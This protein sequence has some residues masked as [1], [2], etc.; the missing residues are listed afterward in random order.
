MKIT[1]KKYKN[2]S[3]LSYPQV[4]GLKSKAAQDKINQVL[5]KHAKDAY[6]FYL[7][8][9]RIGK[10]IKMRNGAKNPHTL[11]SIVTVFRIK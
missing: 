3:D 7:Q 11:A 6:S 1:K 9:K 4:S 5:T 8:A 2:I 10:K